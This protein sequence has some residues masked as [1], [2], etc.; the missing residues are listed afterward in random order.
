MLETFWRGFEEGEAF[1]DGEMVRRGEE[2]MKLLVGPRLPSPEQKK[3][4]I[5]IIWWGSIFQNMFVAHGREIFF[6]GQVLEAP[7]Q[8]KGEVW[9][10]SEEGRRAGAT[11]WGGKLKTR[12][13]W[14]VD[15]EGGRL[16][17]NRK[18]VME[19]ERKE[20]RKRFQ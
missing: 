11:P 12:G 2:G 18:M 19:N 13:C 16:S 10:K 4:N 7:E 8:M 15:G 17:E 1:E 5:I 3:L 6:D 20:K 14:S 9:E